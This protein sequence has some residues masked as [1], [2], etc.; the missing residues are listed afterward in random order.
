MLLFDRDIL[1][2][3]LYMMFLIWLLASPC[4][5]LEAIFLIFVYKKPTHSKATT[6]TTQEKE[7]LVIVI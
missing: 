7:P 2:S 3:T 4:L 1:E 5:L 6:T